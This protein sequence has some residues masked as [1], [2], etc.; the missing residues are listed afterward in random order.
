MAKKKRNSFYNDE[1]YKKVNDENI[2]ILE[3]YVLEM[4]SN[5][6]SEKT[7][8]QYSADIKM[9]FCYM[10]DHM[11]NKSILE[12]K[13]RDFRRFFLA[14][15]ENGASAARINRVQCS[16]RNML[17]FV[18]NDDDEYEDYEINA[19]K[20]IKGLQKEEVREII[21]LTND[22]IEMMIDHL[23]SKEKYQMALYLAFSY[24]SAARRNEV[25]QV[26][27]DGFVEGNRTNEVIGKR[28]KRFQLLY[29][30]KSRE[31]A[32]LYLDQRGED[33]IPELWTVGSGENIR[34][35]KYETLYNWTLSLRKTLEKLTGEYIEF[36]PHSYRHSALENYENGSHYVLGELGRDKLELNVLK[37]LANHESIETTMLYLKNKDEQLLNDTFGL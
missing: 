30:D 33:N 17:E 1:T 28:N 29:F 35:A 20:G 13:K 12:L 34:P 22:Q 7:I 10:Y 8:Y 3:D 19:M 21:F 4:K 24:E 5:G 36:N 11:K 9:F 2:L 26:M 37:A 27:K 25:A 18:V 32:K 23:V 14:L 16:L 31:L 6:R 15:Q